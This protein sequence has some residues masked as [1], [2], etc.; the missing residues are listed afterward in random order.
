MHFRNYIFF[1]I[2]AGLVQACSSDD[3]ATKPLAGSGAGGGSTTGGTTGTT[4]TGTAVATTTG[5]TAGATTGAGGGTGAGGSAGAG[6]STDMPSPLPFTVDSLFAASGYMGDGA[7]PAVDGGVAPIVQEV[8]MACLTTRPPGAVG[9]C[10]KFTYTPT[11]IAAGGLSWAGVYWQYPANNWGTSPGKRIAQG[12]TKVTFYAASDVA[13]TVVT[14][15]V[16]M[17]MTVPYTDPVKIEFPIAL[18]TTMSP[19]I[20]DLSGFT[21]D[22]VLGAF[23]WSIANP[24]GNAAPIA[25][26]V[27]SI[28]WEQ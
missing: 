6:G 1:L 5:G 16:G 2:A 9:H 18:T 7:T 19:Y 21:Y 13:N 11:A 28:R 22:S 12:A 4:V 27:D 14:F 20:V 24:V 10:H 26:T 25:F 3:A 17:T 15:I 8:D 23:A